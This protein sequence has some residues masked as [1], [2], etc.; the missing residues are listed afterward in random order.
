MQSLRDDRAQPRPSPQLPLEGLVVLDFSQFLA[1]PSCAL[2]LADLGADVIKIERPQGGDASR[3][4]RIAEQSFDGSSALFQTI[5]RNKKS[6]AAD[7]KDAQDLMRVKRLVRRADV[8]IHNFRPGVMERL[9]LG[10]E[11]L[12]PINPKLIYAAVTG[13]GTQGPWRDR[14]GRFRSRPCLDR[15][16]VRT[17]CRPARCWCW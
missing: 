10:F 12:A 1:G 14:P 2:R 9:G 13:F 6:F 16:P 7:L 11:T 17:G 4:L 5:N 3:Q 8:M 15:H